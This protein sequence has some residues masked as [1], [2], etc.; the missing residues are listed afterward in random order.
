MAMKTQMEI[1]TIQAYRQQLYESFEHRADA[2]MDLLDALLSNTTAQSVVALSLSPF[3]RRQYSSITDA[4][5]AAIPPHLDAATAQRQQ[6]LSLARLIGPYLP[7]PHKRPFWLLALDATPCPR[8]FAPTLSD[9][10]FVYQPNLIRG[11]KP[12]TIGHQYEALVLLPELTRPDEPHWVVPLMIRRIATAETE[13]Q[14]S[15]D[16]LNM[17]LRDDQLPFHSD[18]SVLVEDSKYSVAN[19]LGRLSLDDNLVDITRSRSNRVYYRVYQADPAQP[20]GRGAPKR[21]GER[22]DLKDTS[23][24][25]NPDETCQFSHTNQRGRTYTVQI[26]AWRNLIMRGTREYRMWDKPFTL[27]RVQLLDENG[28]PIFKRPMW[29]IVIGKRRHELSLKNIWHAYR[30]RYDAEHFFRFGKQRLLFTSYRTPDTEH[31]EMWMQLG[32]VAYTELWLMRHIAQARPNPWERYLPQ[33][34]AGEAT[35]SQV[36]RDAE[37]ILSVIGT[38]AKPPKPRGN[39]SGRAAGTH[40]PRRKRHLVVKKGKKHVQ[41]A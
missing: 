6:K 28:H 19:H 26:E 12:V 7:A 11:N 35:P 39:S 38:P 1:H 14:V 40:M 8:R 31:E 34:S 37:R 17:V 22:F 15:A 27:V 9:R 32:Q 20:R 24:W 30:Q 18:L 41:T 23:T 36:Q 25:G 2:L 5:D 33:P 4:I 10:G 21:Y 16:M 3:F 29:L 13:N